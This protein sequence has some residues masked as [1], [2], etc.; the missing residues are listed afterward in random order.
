[1]VIQFILRVGLCVIL[2]VPLFVLF[3][4]EDL[5]PLFR[6]LAVWVGFSIY[7]VMVVLMAVVILLGVFG[8]NP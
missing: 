5:K 8:E 3:A 7:T 4:W 1:M 2:C 6:R